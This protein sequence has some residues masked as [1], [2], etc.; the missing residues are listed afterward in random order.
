MPTTELSAVGN[1]DMIVNFQTADS[2]KGAFH[3]DY[4]DYRRLQNR[5]IVCNV[6]KPFLQLKAILSLKKWRDGEKTRA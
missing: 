3:M 1:V 2:R 5:K 6:N 4:I